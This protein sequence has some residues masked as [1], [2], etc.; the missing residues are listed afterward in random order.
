MG[1]LTQI[2]AKLSDGQLGASEELL[3]IVYQDLRRLASSMLA[4]ERPG[5]TLQATALVHESYLRLIGSSK[6]NQLW[7][8]RGHFFCAAAQAMRRIIVESARRKSSFKNGGGR[9][10]FSLDSVATISS[11]TPE[12][13][14]DAI[15]A[16]EDALT[17]FEKEDPKK[18]QLVQL[19]YFAGL[20]WEEIAECLDI[21]VAT[22]KRQWQYSRAWLYGKV[23]SD[24]SK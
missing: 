18:A 11:D 3:P 2:L 12:T 17:M 19:R 4:H 23:T 8:H 24:L 6:A 20:S 7:D 21:S 16:L 10:H 9:K 13:A 5:Q 22:A 1:E 15:L 14:D